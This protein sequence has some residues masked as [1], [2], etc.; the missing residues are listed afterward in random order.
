MEEK[1]FN[2][3]QTNI[4]WMKLMETVWLY[5]LFSLLGENLKL[6]ESSVDAKI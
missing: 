5:T 6:G 4:F 2:S 3:N 1:I